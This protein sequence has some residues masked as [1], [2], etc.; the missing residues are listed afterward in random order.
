MSTLNQ[1]KILRSRNRRRGVKLQAMQT[2]NWEEHF[3]KHPEQLLPGA[4]VR[5]TVPIAEVNLHARYCW[6]GPTR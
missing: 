1:D 6:G 3:K 5:R 2:A 4:K